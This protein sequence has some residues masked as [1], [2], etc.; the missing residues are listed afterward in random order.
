MSNSLRTL[1]YAIALNNISVQLWCRG[2]YHAAIQTNKDSNQIL[3]II[4]SSTQEQKKKNY[5]LP[6]EVFASIVTTYERGILRS[7]TCHDHAPS[8]I[9]HQHH[10]VHVIVLND[11]NDIATI[12]N[13]HRV[14]RRT[15]AIY[16]IVL[17]YC[18]FH[19][20]DIELIYSIQLYNLAL[21]HFYYAKHYYL[22]TASMT[23]RQLPTTNADAQVRRI[24]YVSKA[25][26]LIQCAYFAT[27]GSSCCD[28]QDGAIHPFDTKKQRQIQFLMI[29][30]M[31]VIF[32][33][34]I[35]C[36]RNDK[37]ESDAYRR[38]L[39]HAVNRYQQVKSATMD[40]SSC[41]LAAAA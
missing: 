12:T 3:N 17:E 25:A 13:L 7:K 11:E 21:L 24:T 16:P 6:D 10:P 37:K 23:I 5:S 18:N 4:L 22:S 36:N 38:Q 33:E 28:Y 26:Q 27:V 30:S 1:R 29:N 32:R 35:R 31:V 19:A 20:A 41:K 9:D 2:S 40:C 34:N 8:M 15:D 39:T 14:G